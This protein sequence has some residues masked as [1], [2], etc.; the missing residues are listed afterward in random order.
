M[1]LWS[2]SE[3][4]HPGQEPREGLWLSIG[5]TAGQ[6]HREG[7]RRSVLHH[8]LLFFFPTGFIHNQIGECDLDIAHLLG[9]QA[10]LTYVLSPAWPLH[11]R[12]GTI[13]SHPATAV[14]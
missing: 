4:Q 9:L 11:D 5:G 3:S 10:S 14:G 12:L 13:H 8:A 6:S 7:S 1:G 2:A